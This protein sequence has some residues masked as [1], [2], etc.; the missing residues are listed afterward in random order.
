MLDEMVWNMYSAV[1]V[2][3]SAECR[4]WGLAASYAARDA[5]SSTGRE[6]TS[7]ELLE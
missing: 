1:G 5:A 6:R 7:T 2:S 3:R 4:K